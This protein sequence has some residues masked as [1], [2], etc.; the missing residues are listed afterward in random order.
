MILSR[1]VSALSAMHTIRKPLLPRL[2]F[3]DATIAVGAR[4]V[5]TREAADQYRA[6]KFDPARR[7][8]TTANHAARLTHCL[9]AQRVP[10]A[11]QATRSGQRRV[12]R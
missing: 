5:R 7:R 1:M 3:S 4:T 9:L 11:S 8:R 2:A 12:D 10:D 6:L